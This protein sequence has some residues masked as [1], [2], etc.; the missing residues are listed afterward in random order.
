MV[1]LNAQTFKTIVHKP[2]CDIT[3]ALFIFYIQSLE[4]RYLLTPPHLGSDDIFS[5]IVSNLTVCSNTE[6][7]IE[8]TI[9]LLTDISHPTT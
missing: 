8:K 6:F 3:V 1:I 5:P 4:K 7:V 2:N 9:G